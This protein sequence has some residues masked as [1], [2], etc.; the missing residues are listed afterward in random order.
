[1]DR[2]SARSALKRITYGE[3]AAKHQRELSDV[4][5]LFGFS[6]STFSSKTTLAQILIDASDHPYHHRQ[7]RQVLLRPRRG[8]GLHRR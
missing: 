5:D 1:M 4:L 2:N 8:R 6:A 3:F 7:V